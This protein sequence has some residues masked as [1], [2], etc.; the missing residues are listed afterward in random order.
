[1]PPLKS[2]LLVGS[3]PSSN[4][5]TWRLSKDSK[6]DISV[7]WEE[8]VSS[9]S[10]TSTKFGQ[11]TFSPDNIYD[12][13]NL[14]SIRPPKVKTTTKSTHGGGDSSTSSS[15]D[16]SLMSTQT[17][18]NSTDYTDYEDDC[19]GFDCIILSLNSRKQLSNITK[20]IEH[21]VI[22]NHTVVLIDTSYGLGPIQ[23]MLQKRFHQDS[24]GNNTNNLVLAMFTD[25]PVY[26]VPNSGLDVIHSTMET[27]TYLEPPKSNSPLLST[28]I[29]Q[30]NS[31]GIDTIQIS[32]NQK[33][34]ELQWERAIPFIAFQPL[35]IIFD[36]PNLEKLAKNNGLAK[37]L[38]R[39]VIAELKTIANKQGCRFG[40]EF[41]SQF[42]V[43]NLA[44]TCITPTSSVNHNT[45]ANNSGGL[46]SS[47]SSTDSSSSSSLN[48][49]FVDSPLLYYDFYHNFNLRVD[50]LLL[51]PILFADDF[52]I[53]VPYLESIFAFLSQLAYMNS[54]SNNS[55]LFVRKSIT[56]K[57]VTPQ[58]PS[59]LTVEVDP[60]DTSQQQ[61]GDLANKM[62]SLQ[63]KEESLN[64]RENALYQ[65]EYEFYNQQPQQ[66]YMPP[67]P[68]PQQHRH[69]GPKY[70]VNSSLPPHKVA[71]VPV[72]GVSEDNSDGIDMMNLTQQRRSMGFRRSYSSRQMVSQQPQQALRGYP[73]SASLQQQRSGSAQMMYN[74]PPPPQHQPFSQQLDLDDIASISLT[75]NS[76]YGNVSTSSRR[77]SSSLKN[78][79]A[80]VSRSNSMTS[81]AF[82]NNNLPTPQVSQ[83]NLFD[84]F[85][86]DPQQQRRYSAQR[87]QQP[88]PPKASMSPYK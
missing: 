45:Y 81:L 84:N 16:D 52:K 54:H 17:S 29:N 35:S 39:G 70:R 13:S 41:N 67:T 57:N 68:P 73:S 66:Q 50:L 40:D 20:N 86:N 30:F 42:L 56:K 22:P 88:L 9:L 87:Q 10:I 36:T 1:M 34:L 51:Q 25:A 61:Q 55:S 24:D 18:T 85:N 3:S 63:L 78:P 8:K 4:F 12:L 72:K 27:S 48:I 2:I 79:S 43:D 23:K 26:K 46:S 74:N 71:E 59:P 28:V 47:A 44:L 21:L 31:S 37:P 19:N 75:Q 64:K 7:A 38:Y 49:P 33:F 58:T 62:K 5:L 15:N 6:I 53:K 65:R 77:L 83:S 82:G 69:S 80:P 32:S 11:D 14:Q 76:R 60:L